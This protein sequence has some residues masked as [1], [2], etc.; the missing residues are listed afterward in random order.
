M[1]IINGRLQSIKLSY[2]R[3]VM[4]LYNRVLR[5][6]IIFYIVNLVTY[7]IHIRDVD[8]ILELGG[9]SQRWGEK[10]FDH[11]Q[12]YVNTPTYHAYLL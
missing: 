4:E 1:S 2:S 10:M 7:E 3:Y 8:T 12:Q 9:L 11:T 6:I 5:T